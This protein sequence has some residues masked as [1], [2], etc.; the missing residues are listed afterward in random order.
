MITRVDEQLRE[1]V[2]RFGLRHT[3]PSCIHYDDSRRLCSHG[4]PLERHLE[5]DLDQARELVFCKEFE[6]G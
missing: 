6:L 2:R 4:Y 5:V 1:E 3:C